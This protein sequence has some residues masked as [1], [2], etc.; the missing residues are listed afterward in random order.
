M[1]RII[2]QYTIPFLINSSSIITLKLTLK[3]IHLKQLQYQIH[4]SF[5]TRMHVTVQLLIILSN[6]TTICAS[7]AK[8][9]QAVTELSRRL[10]SSTTDPGFF[11][12]YKSWFFIFGTPVA[13]FLFLFVIVSMWAC[14]NVN[15]EHDKELDEFL[16]NEEQEY[17]NSKKS[18]RTAISSQSSGRGSDIS[19]SSKRALLES[20]KT[21]SISPFRKVPF[22]T[23]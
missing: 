21:S 4:C 19:Y 11:E 8:L 12:K 17:L 7:K 3:S 5:K 10:A 14:S 16:Q 1:H 13:V 23:L 18:A 9:R 2:P 20:T 15:D 22:E 6:L